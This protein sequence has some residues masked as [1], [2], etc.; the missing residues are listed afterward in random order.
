MKSGFIG[1]IGRPNVGKSTLMNQ[2]LGEK[3]AITSS[4]P[5]TTLNRITGI[6]TDPDYNN[7]EGIQMV[8][9]DTPGIHKPHN[10]LGSAIN[11]TAV[12]TL[13]GVDVVLLLIDG[14]REF[15]KGDSS[16]LEILRK[17]DTPRI[18]AINKMDLMGPEQYLALY[19]RYEQT[20]MFDDIYGVSALNGENVE[21]LRDRLA[22]YMQ[23]GPMY[24]P[25]DIA[26]DHPERFIV[27]EIIR[28]KLMNY[29]EDEVPHGVFVEIESFEE[30]EKLTEISAVIYCEKKSHKSII[31]GK[32]G[33]KLKGVGKAARKDIEELL[34]CKV[35][36]SLWVKV[37]ENWRDSERT[38][39]S[40]G[41]KDE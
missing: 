11:E 5:Q 8:F 10:K 28:E 37:K 1:I 6:Y 19:N 25:D 4:K 33:S 38:I 15:G 34:G 23:E 16:V 29:L 32:G 39:R 14:T 12:N 22:G 21:M 3:I 7:G 27:S 24:Y 17:T 41:Y 36:L 35:Y 2:I 26:T 13:S 31:I 40:W 9:L 18:L 30:G 20:G